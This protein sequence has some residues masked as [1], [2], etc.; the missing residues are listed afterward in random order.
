MYDQYGLNDESIVYLNLNMSLFAIEYDSES[1]STLYDM[2]N[3]PI[4]NSTLYDMVEFSLCHETISS[5]NDNN[6]G[7]PQSGDYQFQ[8][9]ITVPP[10]SN[11]F[12]SWMYTGYTGIGELAIYQ[13][14]SY[15][16][17][18][19]GHCTLKI[20]TEVED[21]DSTILNNT[22]SGKTTT[23]AILSTVTV[24]LLLGTA[25][26]H[27][28]CKRLQK[29][30]GQLNKVGK[31]APLKEKISGAFQRMQEETFNEARRS[32][33]LGSGSAQGPALKEGLITDV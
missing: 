12:T 2:V 11:S 8:S 19:L 33:N 22:P 31:N 10:P 18:I 6:N 13:D 14:Q 32:W 21:T 7:C 27:S 23:I 3:K 29:E 20:S 17:T 15:G 5:A 30:K 25:A 24:M 4:Y 26:L 28:A 9:S 16:S 1:N